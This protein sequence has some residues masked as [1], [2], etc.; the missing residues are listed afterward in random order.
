MH[1]IGYLGLIYFALLKPTKSLHYIGSAVLTIIYLATLF[2]LFIKVQIVVGIY[3]LFELMFSVLKIL[4]KSL[5]KA[6]CLY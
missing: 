1:Y 5:S 4:E 6:D 3:I 2:L